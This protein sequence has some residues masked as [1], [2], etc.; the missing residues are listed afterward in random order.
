MFQNF[1]L[2]HNLCQVGKEVFHKFREKI[3]KQKD[4][5]NLLVDKEDEGRSRRYFEEKENLNKLLIHEDLYW[6]QR[7]KSFWL[8][9]GDRNLRFL[10]AFAS[11][12]KK[13]NYISHLRTDNNEIIT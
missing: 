13:S 9:E 5:L 3:C 7:S 11:A 2:S 10:H 4:I 1:Y 8:S 6:K 12:K